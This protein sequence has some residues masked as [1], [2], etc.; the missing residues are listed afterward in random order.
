MDPSRAPLAAVLVSLAL[1]AS[2][3]ALL[4]PNPAPPPEPPAA[5]APPPLAPAAAAG[6]DAILL[7]IFL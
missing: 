5:P 3:C 4:R 1:L 6:S 7:T 2:G